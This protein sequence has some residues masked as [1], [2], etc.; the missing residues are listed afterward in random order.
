MMLEKCWTQ[1]TGN[2]WIQG[3]VVNIIRTLIPGLEQPTSKIYG[4]PEDVITICLAKTL[5]EST[6]KVMA[7]KIQRVWRG[8]IIRKF[9]P[10]KKGTWV[11]CWDCGTRRLMSETESVEACAD[12]DC[13]Y[14]YVCKGKCLV[15]CTHCQEIFNYPREYYD[16]T[17]EQSH[18][19]CVRC[20][21]NFEVNEYWSGM[22]IAQYDA[23]YN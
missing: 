2:E 4:V 6:K 1:K 7:T 23:R 19:C 14:K 5:E 16:G 11:Q 8:Y 22:T 21:E 10:L 18:A 20:G 3:H 13:C 9:H 17:G 12:G 15:K